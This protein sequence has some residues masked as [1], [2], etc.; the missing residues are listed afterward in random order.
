MS[1]FS[2]SVLL[3]A[4]LLA[5]NTKRKVHFT[6]GPLPADSTRLGGPRIV[7]TARSAGFHS[8]MPR[9]AKP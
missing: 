1:A 7:S 3:R 9:R 4:Q 5:P 8:F 6:A 2:G